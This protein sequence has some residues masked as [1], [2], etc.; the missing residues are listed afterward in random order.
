M[1]DKA[2]KEYVDDLQDTKIR[3]LSDG[4]YFYTQSAGDI[5]EQGLMWSGGK[6][7]PLVKAHLHITS[8][9]FIIDVS[10]DLYFLLHF[11]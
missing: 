10:I 1:S 6:N 5:V 2:L 11:K 8:N 4:T 3:V 9:G 7:R